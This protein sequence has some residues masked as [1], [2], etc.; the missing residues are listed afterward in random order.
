VGRG[1]AVCSWLPDLTAGLGWESWR[2]DAEILM[3]WHHRAALSWHPVT[4]LGQPGFL[5]SVDGRPSGVLSSGGAGPGH[6]ARLWLFEFPAGIL[7]TF[8]VMPAGWSQIALAARPGGPGDSV[9]GVA[10][11]GGL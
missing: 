11:R 6:H 5:R 3:R 9:V 8:M 2:K 1:G 7:F 10:I 4:G